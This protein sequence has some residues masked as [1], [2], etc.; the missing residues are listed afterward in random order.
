M[1]VP[2]SKP[3]PAPVKEPSQL[4]TILIGSVAGLA[5]CAILSQILSQYEQAQAAANVSVTS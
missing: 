1:T 5:I 2:V 4:G 3:N